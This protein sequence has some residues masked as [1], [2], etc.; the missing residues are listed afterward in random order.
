MRLLGAAFGDAFGDEMRS[1]K[2]KKGELPCE[3]LPCSEWRLDVE[4][5]VISR[6]A[7]RTRS[8]GA[9]LSQ[10]VLQTLWRLWLSRNCAWNW[11]G[12]NLKA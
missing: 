1:I 4:R 11:R 8:L 9:R 10:S 5:R 7:S 12:K 2:A 6:L 3:E